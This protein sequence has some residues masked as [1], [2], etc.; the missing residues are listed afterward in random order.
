MFFQNYFATQKLVCNF[1]EI[2]FKENQLGD[3]DVIFA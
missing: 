2:I 1:P 3:G